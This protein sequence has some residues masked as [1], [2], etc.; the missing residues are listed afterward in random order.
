VHHVNAEILEILGKIQPVGPIKPAAGKGIRALFGKMRER[1]HRREKEGEAVKHDESHPAASGTG[2]L[3]EPPPE[4]GADHH[5]DPK[6]ERANYESTHSRERGSGPLK[7]EARTETSGGT[8]TPVSTNGTAQ[9]VDKSH[10]S[11]ELHSQGEEGA[12]SPERP[13]SDS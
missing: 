12:H 11:G 7:N 5:V 2:S 3:A 1:L 4:H 8:A 13:K 9:G 6:I 10:K